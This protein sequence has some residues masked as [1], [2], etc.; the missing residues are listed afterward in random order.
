MAM[1]M[2]MH[3]ELPS[4]IFRNF[5]HVPLGKTAH[6]VKDRLLLGCCLAMLIGCSESTQ[7]VQAPLE[8]AHEPK[9]PLSVTVDDAD[10]ADYVTK[11]GLIQG[12]L[13][14]AAQLVEVGL[15][16]LGAKH[17]KHP[18]QEVYQELLP[19]FA[20]VGSQGFAAE[21]ETMSGQFSAS[22]SAEFQVSYQAVMSAIDRI[23]A[24]VELTDADRLR[25]AQAL[26]EQAL[27]EYRAGVIAGEIADLQEY[28][29]A[30]GFVEVAETFVADNHADDQRN[31]LLAKIQAAKILWPSLNP[32]QSLYADD[33]A[34]VTV[35]AAL[36]ATQDKGA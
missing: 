16:E 29:D 9:V 7:P 18:A 3:K 33:N 12:H 5:S 22:S 13:W 2:A 32:Q 4:M 8:S 6:A 34:L 10:I 1:A 21:L 25:V 23:V 31:T 15:L 36:R 17:A 19:F 35:I 27:I 20:A 26:I 11:L 24:D 14:V 28:Q 30:R